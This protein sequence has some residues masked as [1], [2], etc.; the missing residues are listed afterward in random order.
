MPLPHSFR[1]PSI[2]VSHPSS[3]SLSSPPTSAFHPL[4]QPAGLSTALSLKEHTLELTNHNVSSLFLSK[5]FKRIVYTLSPASSG[6]GHIPSPVPTPVLPP[7]SKSTSVL[8]TT[9]PLF[10][11]CNVLFLSH[12][13]KNQNLVY[14]SNSYAYTCQGPDCLFAFFN[15]NFIFFPIKLKLH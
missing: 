15:L 7:S 14:S 9:Y 10:T 13:A 6:L 11:K 4:P 12:T 3:N 5:A 8:V 2:S 1:P